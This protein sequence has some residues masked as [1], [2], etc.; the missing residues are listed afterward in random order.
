MYAYIVQLKTIKN[1][2]R[3]TYLAKNQKNMAVKLKAWWR[4]PSSSLIGFFPSCH[5]GPLA[6]GG[7]LL[8]WDLSQLT[9]PAALGRYVYVCVY[10]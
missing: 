2:E 9:G 7:G 5:C 10:I 3:N 1:R 4:I 6:E 8:A